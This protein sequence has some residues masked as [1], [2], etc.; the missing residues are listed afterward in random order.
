MVVL[1]RVV[2]GSLCVQACCVSVCVKALCVCVEV[3]V[4]KLVKEM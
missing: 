3:C 4:F 1:G 2:R